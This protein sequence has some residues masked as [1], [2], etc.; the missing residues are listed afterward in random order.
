MFRG[1]AF[2]CTIQETLLLM[3]LYIINSEYLELQVFLRFSFRAECCFSTT[4]DEGELAGPF[5]LICLAS[6]WIK[7]TV[8]DLGLCYCCLVPVSYFSLYFLTFPAL[9]S[10][11]APCNSRGWE[12]GSSAGELLIF[13]PHLSWSSSDPTLHRRNLPRE[14]TSF[15]MWEVNSVLKCLWQKLFRGR[16]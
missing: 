12:Y 13:L 6:G 8:A 7:G 10:P 16:F 9:F 3:W 14:V 1:P 4:G 15:Y 2:S 5:L 11:S